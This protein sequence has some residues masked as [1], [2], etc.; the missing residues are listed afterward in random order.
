[1]SWQLKL[2][3]L[4]LNG[5]TDERVSIDVG[6]YLGSQGPSA[7]TVYRWRTGRTKPAKVYLGALEKLFDSEQP[8]QDKET[9]NVDSQNHE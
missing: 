5:W 8:T 3:I 6:D 2:Q 9:G 1:M 4:R 7:M